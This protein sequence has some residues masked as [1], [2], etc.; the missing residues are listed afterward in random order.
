MKTL[1]SR[2]ALLVA[3]LFVVATTGLPTMVHTCTMDV[4][5]VCQPASCCATDD[6]ASD[7]CADEAADEACCSDV[8]VVNA[9][10]PDATPAPSVGMPSLAVADLPTQVNVPDPQPWCT[11]ACAER[12]T[13]NGY[14]PPP[15]PA[16]LSVFLI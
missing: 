15:T 4:A 6:P 3:S 5:E 11:H 12:S 7:A 16:R 2:L 10:H 1:R 8:V 9:I 14:G 13:R